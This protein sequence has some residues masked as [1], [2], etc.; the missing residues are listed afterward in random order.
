MGGR[1]GQMHMLWSAPA[2]A[3]E[4]SALY[5]TS[6]RTL[7]AALPPQGQY[8]LH[9]LKASPTRAQSVFRAHDRA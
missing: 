2:D 5:R 7:T 6:A 8:A 9:E 1:C 3:C 4:R